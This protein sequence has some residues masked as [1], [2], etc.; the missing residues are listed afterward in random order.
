MISVKEGCAGFCF[1]ISFPSTNTTQ[2]LTVFRNY[3][4]LQISMVEL[5][6]HLREIKL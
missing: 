3:A 2:E 5:G 6:L 4:T 1:K